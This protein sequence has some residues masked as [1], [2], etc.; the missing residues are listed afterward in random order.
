MPA[1]DRGQIS[2]FL[3]SIGAA[4]TAAGNIGNA[5]S[6]AQGVYRL[7]D[8]T[9]ALLR[10]GGTLA[11][12]DGANLGSVMGSG[13]VVGQAR[14]IPLNKVSTAQSLAAIGPALSMLALQMQL[15]EISG[16]TRTN[17]ALTNQAI[18]GIRSDLRRPCPALVGEGVDRLPACRCPAR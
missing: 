16:L 13:R 4:A 2:T 18:L 17:I 10:A 7:S 14:W 6:G 8:A 5:I 1:G 11:V 9:L 3:A 15:S 12:K